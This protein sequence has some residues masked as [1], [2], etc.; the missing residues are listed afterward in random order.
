M[1]DEKLYL[2]CLGCGEVFDD[3]EVAKVHEVECDN[4]SEGYD[5]QPESEAF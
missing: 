5:I 2:C 1:P 4:P 3:L